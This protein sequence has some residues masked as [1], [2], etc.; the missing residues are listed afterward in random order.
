M[1]QHAHLHAKEERVGSYEVR[2][3]SVAY[4]RLNR[5]N[6]SVPRGGGG[7]RKCTIAPPFYAR[8]YEGDRR[9]LEKGCRLITHT[10]LAKNEIL[11][12]TSK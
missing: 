4:Y 8:T 5:S 12:Y 3:R 2:M 6:W 11:P 9:A 7:T 1:R 10:I